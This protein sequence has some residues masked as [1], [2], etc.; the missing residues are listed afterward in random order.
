MFLVVWSSSTMV[1]LDCYD[2]Y[3]VTVICTIPLYLASLAF[4]GAVLSG[5]ISYISVP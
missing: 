1:Q 5:G 3:H 4:A 2:F